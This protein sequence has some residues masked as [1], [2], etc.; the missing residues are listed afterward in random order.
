MHETPTKGIH[1][2]DWKRWLLWID[3]LVWGVLVLSIVVL[4]WDAFYAGF[5]SASGNHVAE[6]ETM[7]GLARD[8]G[9][10]TGALAW[11]FFR[12]FQLRSQEHKE[13]LISG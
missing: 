10:M 13:P 7:W 8:V 3:L 12:F 2:T 9:L 11:I 6:T 1:E 4:S 5:Y